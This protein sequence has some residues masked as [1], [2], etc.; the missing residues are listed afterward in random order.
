MRSTDFFFVHPQN[1]SEV[2]SFSALATVEFRNTVSTVDRTFFMTFCTFD[3]QE[4]ITEVGVQRVQSS[5]QAPCSPLGGPSHRYESLRMISPFRLPGG[6]E[7]EREQFSL[8]LL[9]RAFKQN[10]RR[11]MRCTVG[12]ETHTFWE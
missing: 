6:T 4:F 3:L 7:R 11:K 10:T 2:I 12:G 1:L 8:L 5:A 9:T